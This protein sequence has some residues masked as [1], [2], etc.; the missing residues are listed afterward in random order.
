MA[1][2]LQTDI[3][4]H[5][6]KMHIHVSALLSTVP[7]THFLPLKT[8]PPTA[9]VVSPG[10]ST[11]VYSSSKAGSITKFYLPTGRLV[12]HCARAGRVDPPKKGKGRERESVLGTEVELKGHRDQV[13]DLALSADGKTLVSAGKDGIVGVWNVEGEEATWVRGLKGHRDSITVRS[14]ILAFSSR[15]ALSVPFFFEVT[16]IAV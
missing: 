8:L 15:L 10:G 9:A 5:S 12:A 1:A 3:Q 11:Y 6:P 13:W 14:L 2:R 4:S 7:A 16:G